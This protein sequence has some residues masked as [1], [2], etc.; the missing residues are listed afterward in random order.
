MEKNDEQLTRLISHGDKKAFDSLYTAWFGQLYRYAFSVLRDE[1]A[2]EE[3]VQNVFMRIWEKRTKIEMQHSVKSYL[4]SAV[5]HE[6]L[7]LLRRNKTRNSFRL[8]A[9]RQNE[10]TITPSA[11]TKIEMTQLET[12]LHQALKDLPE[13]CRSVFQLSRYGGFKYQDIAG[14]LNISVKT[15]EADM[16][17]SLKHLRQKLSDFL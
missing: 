17:R 13:R 2:A 10:T 7:D 8:Q 5:H 11:S 15:V 1:A 14:Q 16:T 4:V 9:V 6:C 12:R 3:T